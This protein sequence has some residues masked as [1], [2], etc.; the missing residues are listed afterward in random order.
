MMKM[1]QILEVMLEIQK[2]NSSSAED[3]QSVIERIGELKTEF[4]G[5]L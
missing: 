5:L 4:A 2:A 1:D 3:A